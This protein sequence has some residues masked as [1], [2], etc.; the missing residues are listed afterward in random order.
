MLQQ[1]VASNPGA[2][3][4]FQKLYQQAPLATAAREIKQNPDITPAFLNK[5]SIQELQAA[6]QK[7][8]AALSSA[9]RKGDANIAKITLGKI[10]QAIA[11]RSQP[12]QPTQPIAPAQPAKLTQRSL[13]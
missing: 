6:E 11:K 13:F 3:A 7:W 9:S 12:T 5:A 1:Y 8:Q 10:K 4:A 2:N